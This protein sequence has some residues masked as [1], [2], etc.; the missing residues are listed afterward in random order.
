MSKTRQSA[1]VVKD[2]DTRAAGVK[3]P[4][5]SGSTPAALA[6]NKE[7]RIPDEIAL[8]WNETGDSHQCSDHSVTFAY[9]C[10]ILADFASKINKLVTVPCFV[11]VKSYFI[12]DARF[13][14]PSQSGGRRA[15]A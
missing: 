12:G 1:S 6:W 7:S 4:L 15:G 14:I 11:P 8:D 5:R 2:D 3:P 13:F 9:H 10:D